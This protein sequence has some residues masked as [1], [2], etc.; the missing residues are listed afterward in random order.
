MQFT[1]FLGTFNFFLTML[2]HFMVILILRIHYYYMDCCIHMYNN[3]YYI[4]VCITVFTL[5]IYIHIYIHII[6]TSVA[7]AKSNKDIHL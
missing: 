7:G 5:H 3:T 4:H 2:M 1:D 6:I